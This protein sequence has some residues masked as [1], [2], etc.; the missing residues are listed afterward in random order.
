MTAE[1]KKI[2][3]PKLRFKQFEGDWKLVKLGEISIPVTEK[4][5]QKQLTPVS[6][7]AGIGFVPQ[8][9]KFGRDISGEQYKNYIVVRDGEFVFNKG[10]SKTF[11]E[12]A[13]Y[14]LEG[15]GE[16]AAPNVFISFKLK[17]GSINE[18]F[19]YVFEKNTHGKE[20]R[21]HIT[22]GA[23]SNG[24]L[25][26]SKET[27]FN[28]ELP[29]TSEEEQTHIAAC[30]SSL[31]AVIS[32]HQ[33]KLEALRQHKRGLMGQLFPQE[34]ETVPR[35]RFPEFA[36]SGA[37]EEKKL[38]ELLKSRPDYG[39]N[40]PAVPF[41]KDLPT[42][43]RI[44]DISEDGKFIQD[45]KVSVVGE[46]TE[47]G[48]LGEN[49]I[50]LARTGA[51]VGKSYLYDY[52]DGPLVFAG[53]LIRIRP[54]P[55]RLNSVFLINYFSTEMYWDWVSANSARSGQPGINSNEYASFSISLP[56]LSEQQRIAGCLSSLDELIS[57]QQEKISE[58]AKF[59]RSLMQ[60]LFPRT[61]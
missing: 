42:Y 47:N 19:K 27:F 18:F 21:P 36:E 4:V 48:F 1:P 59:K 46:I 25:N 56:S 49:E 16:V 39:L 8:A 6:I 26:I 60:G 50:V 58:L 14:L 53:F 24:L 55:E 43:L 57:A 30:L 34:G 7:S 32:A 33:S 20:L 17:K 61:V 13:I 23:R 35:L 12:G 45:R 40:A 37:W 41:S 31:D 2:P 44:T 38:G 22:S 10:N 5:G 9:E 54:N 3:A 52:K 28:I 15:W 51:S 29:S 11:P